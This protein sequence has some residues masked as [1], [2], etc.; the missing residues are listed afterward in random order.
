MARI[1]KKLRSFSQL[2]KYM[3]SERQRFLLK[4]N[5]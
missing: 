4:F 1:A 5:A 2:Q 3:L